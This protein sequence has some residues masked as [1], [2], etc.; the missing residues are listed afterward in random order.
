[1]ENKENIMILPMDIDSVEDLDQ[2]MTQ[3]KFLTHRERKISND[4]S[5]A[6][7]GENNYTR[8]NKIRRELL[9]S[10]IDPI[11]DENTTEDTI[12]SETV[13]ESTTYSDNIVDPII[14][15]SDEQWENMIIKAR[16]AESIGMIIMVDTDN[17]IKKIGSYSFD[18]LDKLDKKWSNLQY[19]SS[20]R[21]VDSNQIAQS[22]FGINNDNL[23]SSI[24]NYVF[25]KLEH[26]I[27][28]DDDDDNFDDFEFRNTVDVEIDDP[29]S[30]AIRE[31]LIEDELKS[32]TLV[33]QIKLES[34]YDIDK[35]ELRP[36]KPDV[37]V[38]FFTPSEMINFGIFSGEINMYSPKPD[39]DVVGDRP[40]YE[41]FKK[42]QLLGE[43]S[44]SD[45]YL[46]IKKLNE[47]YLDY[48]KII[49]EGNINKISS[50]KQ[51]ILELGW[52][53]EIPF[54]Q[55][56]AIK[57][58]LR[59]KII[60]ENHNVN[61]KSYYKNESTDAFVS[62]T[63]ESKPVFLLFNEN[64]F[65]NKSLILTT[66]IMSDNAHLFQNTSYSHISL[67]DFTRNGN[68]YTVSVM[69]LDNIT[70]NRLQ[71]VLR[72]TEQ[73]QDEIDLLKDLIFEALSIGDNTNQIC[74]ILSKSFA[75]PDRYIYHLYSGKYSDIN[76][77][78]IMNMVNS[79]VIPIGDNQAGTLRE[80]MINGNCT[81]SEMRA[82][83]KD[84]K[85]INDIFE[86]ATSKKVRKISVDDRGN[87]RIKT[88]SDI[89]AEFFK[90]HRNLLA[91]E[92]ADNFASMKDELC[93]LKFLDN[94]AV[95]RMKNKDNKDYKEYADAHARIT[96]DFTKYLKIVTD[97]DPHFNF[98]DYYK[99]S[100]WYDGEVV[101]SRGLMQWLL[102][103]MTKILMK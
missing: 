21:R 57:A 76:V 40:V 30:K 42:Y 15:T 83:S 44:E 62:V 25:N 17:P 98:V 1:M 22:I 47:L 64:I 28:F 67:S 7:Y 6:Q 74:N 102:D 68:H 92:K 88:I 79:I 94:I 56:A 27:A 10:N 38:P 8:Y 11:E 49:R 12:S 63:S 29:L 2:W 24:K 37:P 18:E 78:K 60:A 103:I 52:N 54:N 73:Y 84:Y 13:T 70:W 91:Y 23:Y 61:L 51:S 66:N 101:I 89:N 86:S 45:R 4:A 59:N 65:G 69:F 14:N 99:E 39:N 95:N 82:S 48:D 55:R 75:I 71:N 72:D 34:V 85:N 81:L 36:D 80:V 33:E 58:N 41:W 96:N 5:I 35:K 3:F 77:N 19:L 50:R 87:L 9:K 43:L 46:W 31:A 90:S 32:C 93:K 53:P 20:K 100:E 26:M 16:N 97:F